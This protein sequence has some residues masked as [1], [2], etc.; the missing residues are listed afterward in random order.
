SPGPQETVPLSAALGRV[1]AQDVTALIDVPPFDRANVDGFALR[2]ADTIGANDI[3]PR[4]LRL[5]AE[6]IVCGHAPTLQVDPDSATTIATGGVIPPG[7]RAALV[8][9]HTELIGH[10]P[11][12]PI[13]LSPPAGPRP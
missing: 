4:R 6:V 8:R 3:T 7:A 2:S 12:P 10:D 13:E 1:L 9:V 5:N 11:P